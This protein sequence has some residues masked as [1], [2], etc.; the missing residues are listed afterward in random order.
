MEPTTSTNVDDAY[1]EALASMRGAWI[2]MSEAA[3]IGKVSAK[4]LVNEARNGRL[5]AV[6]IGVKRGYRT[7]PEWVEEWLLGCVFETRPTNGR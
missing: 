1:R 2:T 7:K 3:P 5:R 6:R 4:T